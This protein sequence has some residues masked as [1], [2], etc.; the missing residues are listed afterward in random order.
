M[1]NRIVGPERDLGGKGEW[2][3]KWIEG[4]NVRYREGT[5]W[6]KAGELDGFLRLHKGVLIFLKCLL[7]CRRSKY[8]VVTAE[9]AQRAA[10]IFDDERST[11]GVSVLL[12]FAAPASLY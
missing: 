8:D 12:P 5:G 9:G 6:S 7:G 11:S 3:I 4:E 1:Q 10:K 2:D